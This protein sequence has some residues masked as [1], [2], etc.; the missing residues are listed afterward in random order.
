MGVSFSTNSDIRKKIERQ[1]RVVKQKIDKM[2][3]DGRW[4]KAMKANVSPKQIRGRLRMNY[5]NRQHK[6]GFTRNK[7]VY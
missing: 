5:H 7:Y 3:K 4:K 2:K 6:P 1:E